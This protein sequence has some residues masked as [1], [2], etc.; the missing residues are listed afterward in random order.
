MKDRVGSA[1]AMKPACMGS[2]I[3]AG[4][5]AWTA[6][7]AGCLAAAP[8][9][10]GVPV[11][12]ARLMVATAADELDALVS[13]ARGAAPQGGPGGQPAFWSAAGALQRALTDLD[14]ALAA[15]DPACLLILGEAQRS[16]VA[17]QVALRRAGAWRGERAAETG[18]P[19]SAGG[20]ETARRMTALTGVVG[21]LARAFG[22]EAVP[23][24]QRGDGLSAAQTLQLQSMAR[25]A[26][27]W[28]AA[29]PALTAAARQQGD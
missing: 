12:E 21:R 6:M 24:A 7:P 25:A 15:G 19:G 28:R 16:L 1:V 29:L 9:Q 22:R 18:A 13:A 26:R 2:V 11:R 20:E 23:A 3:L 27:A 4:L 14:G 17:V 5:L 10:A 8:E